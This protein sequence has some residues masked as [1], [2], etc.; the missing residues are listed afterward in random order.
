MVVV[1][2]GEVADLVDQIL[3]RGELAASQQAAG[4]DREEDLDLVEPRG[5]FG[6]VVDGKP[7]VR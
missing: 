7:R 5:V 3:A 4:Q 6:R 1:G 2:G